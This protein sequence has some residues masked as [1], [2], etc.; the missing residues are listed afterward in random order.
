MAA[1]ALIAMGSLPV[2]TSCADDNDPAP[3]I[4]ATETDVELTGE[5]FDASGQPVYVDL[6]ANQSWKITAKPDWV[7]INH[8]KGDRGRWHLQ[9]SAEVNTTGNDRSGVIEFVISSGKPEQILVTQA[10]LADKLIISKKDFEVNIAGLDADGKAPQMTIDSNYPWTIVM[11]E[12]I[13][14]VTPSVTQ[15]EAGAATVTFRV[16]AVPDN[17]DRVARF[18]VAT[19]KVSQ[20]IVISQSAKVFTVPVNAI[21]LTPDGKT[22]TSGQQAVAPVEAI[23]A[24]RVTSKPEW[25]TVAPDHG[26]AGQTIVSITAT[27]NTA[28]QRG[29]TIV[30]TST[31]NGIFELAVE[32]LGAEGD[33]PDDRAVG[34]V[35][36]YD[37]MDWAIEGADVIGNHNTKTDARN[38]LGGWE[39]TTPG[40]DPVAEFKARY[41]DMT[42]HNTPTIYTMDGYIKTGRKDTQ[43]YMQ[44]IQPLDIPVGRYA[45]IEISMRVA[46]CYQEVVTAGI[47]IVGDGTVE[48]GE[49]DK[50]GTR[51]TSKGKASDGSFD[52]TWHDYKI[53]VRGATSKTF[54]NFG[55]IYNKGTDKG[56]WRIFIDDLKV[57]RIETKK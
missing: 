10:R 47:S 41:K 20:N 21:Q 37:P 26:D 19:E 31:H 6:G 39:Y 46:S 12:D 54:I 56:Y 36:F 32:Q 49:S 5:G 28:E 27:E 48:N 23:E 16:A 53:I 24:W 1:A 33:K 40:I 51:W 42:N 43:T 50:I 25:I 45:D 14:W 9:I 38:L 30:L 44:T 7:I 18:K 3:Y 52:Y 29:G 34:Y 55:Q 11:P 13:D 17:K 35:Y 4:D 15:G 57:T 8:E 2:V 22:L